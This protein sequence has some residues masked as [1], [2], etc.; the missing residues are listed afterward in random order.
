MNLELQVAAAAVFLLSLLL[1][2]WKLNGVLLDWVEQKEGKG[3]HTAT[4]PTSSHQQGTCTAEG[5]CLLQQ[6]Q[7]AGRSWQ[8]VSPPGPWGQGV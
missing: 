8:C 2:A 1:S 6:G 5:N 4:T 3:Q 7:Q